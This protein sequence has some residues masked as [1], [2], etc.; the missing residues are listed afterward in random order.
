MNNHEERLASLERDNAMNKEMIRNLGE[1]VTSMH[2]RLWPG[3]TQYPGID[4]RS[5]QPL[6]ISEEKIRKFRFKIMCIKH[7]YAVNKD[8]ASVVD[9]FLET[10]PVTRTVAEATYDECEAAKWE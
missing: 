5:I 9:A 8:K 7:Y 4:S 3:S 6:V 1:L 2:E 10:F